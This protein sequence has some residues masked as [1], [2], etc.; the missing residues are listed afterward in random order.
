[1]RSSL[2]RRDFLKRSAAALSV[3]LL[4]LASTRV[5]AA[6]DSGS[7]IKVVVW[8]ER[9]PV[10]KEAY[11]N[12]LGNAIA[13]HLRKQS[14]FSVK[15][16][17]MD[18]P[19]RGLSS[20]VLGDCDVL[21]WW[22]HVRHREIAPEVVKPLI[23]RIKAGTLSLISLHSAHWSTLFVEAMNARTRLDVEAR[24]RPSPDGSER[25]E[26]EYLPAMLNALAKPDAKL[27]PHVTLKKFP[28][29]LT[30]VTVQLPSC[31]FPAY[32]NDGK[33]SDVRVVKPEHPIVQGVPARFTLPR[34]E[35]YA[36]PFHVPEPDEVILEERWAPGEWFRSGMVWKIG[37]GHVFYFRPGHETY[38]I[39]HDE[40]P[41]KI[42]TNAARWLASKPG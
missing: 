12:F 36:E 11:P 2:P 26:F 40:N 33:P 35:M 4:P 34:T 30:K 6:A 1:M 20:E 37:K 16:V 7:A 5:E 28:D 32:R 27:T 42:V 23:E 9:Q 18:D 19:E 25:V 14:G 31:V 3:P 21:I 38:P 13:D 10:Q 41:L 15:S 8:D 24:Y 17:G 29:G 22:G 39:F